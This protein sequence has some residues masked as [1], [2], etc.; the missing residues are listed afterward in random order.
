M[1]AI[2]PGISAGWAVYDDKTKQLV[3]C[4]LFG[5]DD[6]VMGFDL[7][8]LTRVVYEKPFVYPRSPV[9]PNN[10]ITLAVRAG[11]LVERMASFYPASSIKEYLPR[12][13]KG[14][15]PKTPKLANYIVYK[16]IV[17]RLS[18]A[19]NKILTVA[20]GRLTS[21]KPKFDVVDAVGIGLHD[22]GRF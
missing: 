14:Q 2:D 11:R 9:N 18:P 16:R 19:E 22:V 5:G 17:V 1:I 21:E 13:W 6:E 15:L 4:G 12:D 8:L 3:A 10:L 7:K 20:L